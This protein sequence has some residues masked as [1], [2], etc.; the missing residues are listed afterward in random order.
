MKKGIEFLDDTF[1]VLHTQ[2]VVY[3]IETIDRYIN[4]R[5]R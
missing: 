3:I 4:S 5:R 1:E 2:D